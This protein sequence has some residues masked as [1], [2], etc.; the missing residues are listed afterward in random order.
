MK[1]FLVKPRGFCA[2][3]VRAIEIVEKAIDIWGAPIYVKHEIVHNKH[4]VERLQNKGVIF[5]ED[6]SL[7]P[8]N[9]RL[10]Y[11]AHGVSPKVR[12]LSKQYDLI[13]IDATCPLV[14]MIHKA[15]IDYSKKGY[16]IVLI[17]KKNHVEVIG[18]YEES[19]ENTVIVSSKEDASNL[20]FSK[21]QKLLYLVQTTFSIDDVKCIID[22]LKNKYPNIESLPRSSSCYATQNRQRA[23]KEITNKVD[24]VLVVGDTKSSNSN[25][26]REIAEKQN[27]S[28]YLVNDKEEIKKEWLVN[29]KNIAMTAGASTPEN[30]V[31]ECIEKLNEIGLKEIEEFNYIEEKV[32]FPLPSDF[33]HVSNPH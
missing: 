7:V 29:V 33:F 11:S 1:L 32:S 3:V 9:S 23:L 15:I 4:V 30:I 2:G 31:Q 16:K 20:K 24:I 22:E 26:L 13:D 6:L 25:R 19:E 5:I 18:A 21:N 27:I 28:A 17:G 14:N 12:K 10:I 8:K